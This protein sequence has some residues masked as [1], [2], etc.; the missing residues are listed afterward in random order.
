MES[1]LKIDSNGSKIWYLNGKKHRE[2]GPAIIYPNGEK[3]W[4]LNG[5]RH[6]EDGPAVIHP[7]GTKFWYKNGDLYREDGP[8][9]IFSDGTKFWYKNGDLIKVLFENNEYKASYNPCELCLV[10]YMCGKRC[11]LK[12][13]LLLY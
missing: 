7:N 2:N 13:I 1:E 8:A 9:M 10:N 12:E 5:Q 4:Y 3:I 11:K 6:R